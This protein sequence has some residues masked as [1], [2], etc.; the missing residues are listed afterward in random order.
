MV[1]L[2]PIKRKTNT[3]ETKIKKYG[4]DENKTTKSDLPAAKSKFV[5]YKQ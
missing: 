4:T 2:A 1:L 5:L 3:I